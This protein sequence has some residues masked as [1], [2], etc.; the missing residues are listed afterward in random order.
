ML[1]PC[2]IPE[3]SN[4]EEISAPSQP[5]GKSQQV[6][7]SQPSSKSQRYGLPDAMRGIAAVFIVWHHLTL[8][9]PQ[10]ELADL[11]APDLMFF[12][13]N[14]ALYAVQVFMVI[15][16]FSLAVSMSGWPQ[17]IYAG[18]SKL[19][20]KYLRI[21]I[22]CM[23]MLAGLLLVTSL[24]RMCGLDLG[25]VESV[26]L[27]Q[28]IASVFFLQDVLGFGNIAAGTWYLCIDLQF[29]LMFLVLYGVIGIF[30]RD[31]RRG[32]PIFASLLS[33]LGLVGA[34]YWN[35]RLEYEC[36]VF[37]FMAS[38]VLGALVGL[39]I[40]SRISPNVVYGYVLGLLIAWVF[41][42]RPQ[43]AVALCAGT[44]L[45]VGVVRY[46]NWKTP[47]WLKWLGDRSYSL[48]LVHYLVNGVVLFLLDDW[49]ITGPA[50]AFASMWLA[51]A[52]SLLGSELF[53]RWVEVPSLRLSKQLQSH[54][55]W[56]W[57]GFTKGARHWVPGRRGAPLTTKNS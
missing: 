15:G 28:I 50:A 45:W 43:L 53:W 1:N 51:F 16:G 32:L 21:G 29:S 48:F 56:V 12:L 55:G 9:A 27:G 37:Y 39:G 10:S 47:R 13:Y 2:P 57:R 54:L 4:C 19:L 14:R 24:F 11:I 38:F 41:Q 35:G 18:A 6:V 46:P 33:S 52:A 49:A 36:Y 22:P 3:L 17:G 44:L 7:E 8:F 26:T 42:P 5:L 25:L 34:F 20:A 23:V 31:E 30:V 40:R